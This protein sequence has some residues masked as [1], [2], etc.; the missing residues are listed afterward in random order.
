LTIL[1]YIAVLR[2]SVLWLG[3][4]AVEGDSSGMKTLS[5]QYFSSRMEACISSSALSDAM[6]GRLRSI[7]ST[8]LCDDSVVRASCSRFR[9]EGYHRL[10]S[11]CAEYGVLVLD[12]SSS[13][14]LAHLDGADI[15]STS[16]LRLYS[17]V[18]NTPT[19]LYDR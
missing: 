6:S 8:H 12:Y 9:I 11:S 7:P 4:E 1:C 15:C 5:R 13:G 16:K 19:I 10:A 14:Q 2:G 3:S 18:S 17:G